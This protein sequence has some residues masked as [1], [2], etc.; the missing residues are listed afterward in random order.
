MK[1]TRT[2]GASERASRNRGAVHT[3]TRAQSE[4]R[5]QITSRHSRASSVCDQPTNSLDGS[6][7]Y[8]RYEIFSS[9]LSLVFRALGRRPT[10][11][12][13]NPLDSLSTC[14]APIGSL[15]FQA[16]PAPESPIAML[17]SETQF[18]G[19]ELVLTFFFFLF[20]LHL[21]LLF[22]LLL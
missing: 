22:L 15:W 4:S 14:G 20:F 21:L 6:Q 1:D 11:W 3:R 2:V 19:S 8:R 10:K 12:I 18:A 13:A 5:P 17:I 9:F 7:L 16:V